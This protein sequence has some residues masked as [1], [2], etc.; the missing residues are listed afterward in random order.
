MSM[1]GLSDRR[2]PPILF[3]R[4]IHEWISRVDR[5][6]TE[7]AAIE[8]SE[9]ARDHLEQWI[10]IEFTHSMLL[11]GG[12]DIP[13]P[14]IE[15]F[16]LRSTLGGDARPADQSI[17]RVIEAFRLIRSTVR[18]DGPGA[19]LSPELLSRINS[20]WSDEGLRKSDLDSSRGLRSVL[21][22]HVPAAV[23]AACRWFAAPS[24][25]EL[26]P[27]E[28]A[29]IVLLRLIEIHPFEKHN[30]STAFVA[31][32]LHL[33]PAGL[34]PV[35][36]APDKRSAFRAALEEG[37]RMNT[38]PIVEVLAESAEAVLSSLIARSPQEGLPAR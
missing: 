20:V 3:S 8:L 33:L 9:A 25:M 12:L 14:E 30:E 19:A 7:L 11:F 22:A 38:K 10:E 34:P 23:E 35:I 15:Q 5:K 37:L 32:S 18:G 24:F 26:H 4:P 2:S 17:H 36:I 1:E 28:R 31:A 27:L 29:G 21:Q 16:V 6:R 13:R